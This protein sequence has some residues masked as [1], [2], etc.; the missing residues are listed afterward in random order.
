MVVLSLEAGLLTSNL[1]LALIHILNSSFKSCFLH[2]SVFKD[3]HNFFLWL[4]HPSLLCFFSFDLQDHKSHIWT[5]SHRKTSCLHKRKVSHVQRHRTKIFCLLSWLWDHLWT[6][7]TE[8]WPHQGIL[9]H[10]GLRTR[11]W[12]CASFLFSRVKFLLLCATPVSATSTLPC[13]SLSSPAAA[14][15]YRYIPCSIL[16]ILTVVLGSWTTVSWGRRSNCASYWKSSAPAEFIWSQEL[17]H[18]IGSAS[19]AVGQIKWTMPL[20][21]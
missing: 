6:T 12:K 1:H 7:S 14:G 13:C 17:L 20:W 15:I 11:T 8:V 16:Y 18:T 9:D 2:V 19:R 10:P 21:T 4:L 5:S 3:L